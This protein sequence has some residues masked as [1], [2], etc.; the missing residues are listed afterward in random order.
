[1]RVMIDLEHGRMKSFQQQIADLRD[2]LHSQTVAEH[3]S[4]VSVAIDASTCQARLAKIDTL[5]QKT[6]T[7]KKL[8]NRGRPTTLVHNLS[9]KQLSEPQTRV[10]QRDAGFN[11]GDAK[12]LDFLTAVQSAIYFLPATED[13]KDELKQRIATIVS[14]H[15]PT[16]ILPPDEAEAL[17]QLK[18]DN[19]IVILPA[20]KG[21]ATVV[22]DRTDY[23][24]KAKTLLMDVD[25]Y[26][27][28]QKNPILSQKRRL[29]KRICKLKKEKK[30]SDEEAKKI[31]PTDAAIARF[32]GFPKIHKESVPLRPIVSLRGTPM[33]GLAEWLTKGLR[34]LTLHSETNSRSANDFLEK[35]RGIKM[36]RD[37]VMV[38][39]DVVSLFSKIPQPLAVSTIREL[40]DTNG[41]PP[42]LAR[43][44][45]DEVIE[46]LEYALRTVF[47]FD[48]KIFEQVCGTPMGSPISGVI[49]EAVLQKLERQVLPTSQ[50]IFWTR[51]VDDTFVI[52][53][54]GQEM[55]LQ[56]QLNSVFPEIQFTIEIEQD[57][58]LP[59]LD[60]LVARRDDGTLETSVYRKPTH[61]DNMLHAASNHPT[62]HKASCIR[63][64]YRRV[65][66]H[67]SSPA[68]KE[69][70]IAT[71]R[72]MCLTNG[73][74]PATVKRWLERR[75]TPTDRN[76]E[77]QRE[78]RRTRWCGAP[79]I[80][81]VS[82]PV[83]RLL[84]EHGIRL[85]HRPS[86]T[87]RGILMQAKDRLTDDEV[88]G[89]IYSIPCGDCS[90]VY[91]GQTDRPLQTRI[92]EHQ[93][94]VRRKDP[95][96]Q[97]SEHAE[98]Y[99]HHFDF[100]RVRIV[101]REKT[102]G[103]RLFKEAWH[104]GENAVNRHV[105][106]HPAF[107]ALRHH[108]SAGMQP[109]TPPGR[110]RQQPAT[111]PQQPARAPQQRSPL[112]SHLPME[113]AMSRHRPVTRAMT[114]RQRCQSL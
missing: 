24:E 68:A 54:R 32:Y 72:R 83:A 93:A 97:V 105:D 29:R 69:Q 10:L 34:P 16:R 9:S 41:M 64:L 61:T 27:V 92:G 52:L 65:D 49:A 94:A 85:A 67:C 22:M 20:D 103:G 33:F 18:K 3:F 50:H 70:E 96:S 1:M 25:S 40:I 60:V 111:Q 51:Y 112:V 57:N 4:A 80:N 75:R 8:D 95:T 42:G 15:Q 36:A 99:K 109:A 76:Q 35:I 7:L 47:T 90:S 91:V 101:D 5:R 89:T 13:V 104:S 6:A 86:R 106:L 44:T 45:L 79:Y 55:Q 11:I 108:L 82:E 2:T 43:L 74:R 23:V 21:R 46:L 59:F 62:S 12:P 37:E 73:Y 31:R 48:G 58:C 38:S 107:R 102:Y 87:L 98:R 17:Q 53:K 26:R 56:A 78:E 66:T 19:T 28:L 39:F 77:E 30:L 71:L 110:L 100:D 14:H 88:T 63:S 113:G 81:A 84:S 114:R